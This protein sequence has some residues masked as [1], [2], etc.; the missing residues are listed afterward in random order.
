MQHAKSTPKNP[1]YFTITCTYTVSL[2]LESKKRWKWKGW[3][4][5]YIGDGYYVCNILKSY[6]SNLINILEIRSLI[7]DS[8][9]PLKPFLESKHTCKFVP[10][11]SFHEKKNASH[12]SLT[13]FHRAW[14]N[15]VKLP[16]FWNFS[17]ELTPN[18]PDT[19]DYS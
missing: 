5:I 8:H 16:Y 13:H 1:H 14:N 4:D 6:R 18:I 9:V 12:S 2:A 11:N 7:W 10:V 3:F 19:C 17:L 15:F